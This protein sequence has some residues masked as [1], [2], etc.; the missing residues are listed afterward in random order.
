MQSSHDSR[1]LARKIGFDPE[2][3]EA[4]EAKLFIQGPQSARRLTNFRPSL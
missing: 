2:H 1:A 3:L 4:F